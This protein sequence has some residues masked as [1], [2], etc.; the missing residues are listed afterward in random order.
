MPEFLLAI[1][2]PATY[3]ELFQQPLP[4]DWNVELRHAPSVGDGLAI[5]ESTPDCRLVLLEREIEPQLGRLVARLR[6]V[7]P[8]LEIAV[9]SA[10][11]GATVRSELQ[12]LRVDLLERGGPRADLLE[13][14]RRHFRRAALKAQVGLVGLSPHIHAILETVLQVGPTDIPVLITGPSGAGKE[15]VARAL[16]A[17]GRR[18]ERPFVALNVGALA[19]SVLE[20]ELFGHEKGAFTG[21]VARK[22]GVFERADGG[23]LFLD[24]VGEMSAHMQVR[25]LRAL[26]RGEITPVGGTQSR[27]VDVR[28]VAA[29]NRDLQ[30]AVERGTFREDLYYRLK[31]VHL[32]LPGLASRRDDLPD[33]VQ[34]FLAESARLYGTRARHVSEAAMHRLQ[35]HDWPGNVREL[36]NVVH[37]MAVLARGESLEAEDVPAA[38]RGAE[39]ANL[40][41]PMHR[42]HEQA[43]RDV[44]LSSLLALRRDLQEVLLLLRGAAPASARAVLVDPD[45]APV[46]EAPPRSLRQNEREMLQ[47][48]LVAV[49][50][51]RRLA[52]QRLGIAERTL[53]RKL[54]E[55]GLR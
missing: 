34:Y 23:T 51:N 17:A 25:L 41:V 18:A 55:F 30:A 49:G 47:E 50:G 2:A 6:R 38:I 12:A 28:L 21:A 36:R 46:V 48:A 32:D 20:S 40:P 33:L 27:R 16:V 4:A 42:T 8:G 3:S 31:V 14:L 19:E 43:E 7:A 26:D 24:E 9:L 45:E 5:L 22:A 35:S 1:A 54:K 11:V 44:I 29:T 13:A 52:A 39:S 10:P 15:L 37:S 53:Y